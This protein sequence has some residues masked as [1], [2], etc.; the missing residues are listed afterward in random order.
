MFASGAYKAQCDIFSGAPG[1]G[2]Q[3]VDPDSSPFTC[4]T[5]APHATSSTEIR[6]T[7]NLGLNR[8]AEA[9]GAI[10]SRGSV[11]LEKGKYSTFGLPYAKHGD[12][13]VPAG[14]TT[15][16]DTVLRKG[17]ENPYEN[18]ARNE[19]A[20]QIY[21]KGEPT[22]YWVAG[23]STNHRGGVFNGDSRCGIYDSNPLA[24]HG[25]LDQSVPLSSSPYT[26]TADGSYKSG[27]H[28]D[29]RVH[30]FAQFTVRRG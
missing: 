20:Y 11:S 10:S 17:D 2:G 27:P 16:F 21:F 25:E 6:F 26:C 30:Y 1:S 15:S 8:D 13:S 28:E 22:D 5:T 23:L 24:N 14:G 18:Q 9:S 4:S 3:L 7:F 19:F 29:G 12:E